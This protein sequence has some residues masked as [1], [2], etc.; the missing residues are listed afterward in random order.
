[1]LK[2]KL[3]PDSTLLNQVLVE[4][5]FTAE[6]DHFLDEDRLLFGVETAKQR[7]RRVGDIPLVDRPVVEELGLVAHLFDDVVGRIA[8]GASDSQVQPIG[9]V[10]AE[11]VPG[12]VET[13]PVLFL[14]RRQLP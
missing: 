8:L 3:A 4:T 5:A 9:T 13:G 6:A 10:V 11:I 1:M 12:A 2:D 7:L 14:L